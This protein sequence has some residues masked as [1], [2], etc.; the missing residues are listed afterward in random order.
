[1]STNHEQMINKLV[2]DRPVTTSYNGHTSPSMP[3][4]E[5]AREYL[6]GNCEISELYPYLDEYR[7]VMEYY[8]YKPGYI[9]SGNDV[10]FYNRCMAFLAL[11]CFQFIKVGQDVDGFFGILDSEKLNLD[12]QLACFAVSYKSYNEYRRECS[13]EVLFEGA[14][15]TFTHYLAERREET[16]AAFLKAPAEGRFLALRVLRGNAEENKKEILGYAADGSKLVREELLDILY[17]KKDWADSIRELLDAK[18]AAIREM[19]I[20]VLAHWQEENKAYREVLLQA[21]EKEKNTKVLT[22]LQNVLDIQESDMPKDE[23]S[24][25]EL[26]KQLHKGGKKKSLAWAYET[27]FSAVHKT[28]GEAADEEYLQA[29]LLCY[30]SQNGC[31][32][33]KNAELLAND[34]D[35]N[36]FAVYVNELF[37]KWLTAGAE[38]K[39]KWALYAAAIHG[40][41]EI[42][43]KIRHQLQEWPQAARGAIAAEAVKALAL[44][45]SPSALLIVD[46]ISRKFKFKQ[47][48]AAAGAA[49]EFAASQLG[50]TR[51]ELSDR[52]VPDLGFDENMERIFDYGTRT[53]KVRL[54]TALDIEVY[55]ENGKKLKSLPAPAKKDDEQKAAAAYEEFKQLKKQLK[56][57][58]ASQ[59]SRLE[60][61]L[62]V[63]REW[64]TGAW[65]A[66]FVKNP[67]M[68]QFATGLIWGVYEDG[69]LVQ[70]F[71]YMEDGSFNT[72]DEDEYDMPENAR[73]G[74]VH[75]IELSDEEI[76][77]WKQQLEDYEISQPVEQLSRTVYYVEEEE[78]D[79]KSM[80]RFGGCI[81]KDLSL[82]GKLTALGWY[83]GSVQ[84]AGGFYT[85]YRED[86]ELG[87]GVELNFSGSY[88]G[89]MD[90]DITVYDARFYK[91]GTVERGSYVYDE[92]DKERSYFLKDVPPRY[93]SEVVYQLALATVSSTEKDKDWKKNVRLI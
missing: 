7:T 36:E 89:M 31:G 91:A 16:I 72:V 18:K 85:Y 53:F 84:D 47:V 77:A 6:R 35:I 40:G 57:T 86:A 23:A 32:I 49:L 48:K 64:E 37:D 30:V 20:H 92:A 21:M 67:L 51:E 66:L 4:A 26:V 38:S 63:K 22:L 81:L 70:S 76:E 58:I 29:V 59:K 28:S 69:K 80:E 71:R 60:F 87:M 65:R 74:L 43:N 19:A 44:N 2:M 93:F 25:E 68:H 52:I 3:N 34:L 10:K 13:S 56:T 82:N 12:C 90:E 73:I 17:G 61:A 75:P 78:K 79:R 45:P 27:P 24:K 42:I 41:E 83:R 62:S 46:G 55:D 9:E 8:Q 33:S 14:I 5:K 11:S 88:V 1:M 39:K 54:T 50:I 15:K